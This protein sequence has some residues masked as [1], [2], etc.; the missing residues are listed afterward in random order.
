M[1]FSAISIG[2]RSRS[3]LLRKTILVMKLTTLMLLVALVQASARGYGQKITLHENSVPL[4]N[5]LQSIKKQTGYVFISNNFDTESIKVSINVKDAELDDALRSCFKD[6]PLSYKIVEKTV[7]IEQREQSL[8]D[9]LKA[10]IQAPPP[11]HIAGVLLDVNGRALPSVSVRVKNV[12]LKEITDSQGKFVIE[13]L[14]EGTV[15]QFTMVGFKPF[16]GVI[17]KVKNNYTIAAVD[18]KQADQIKIIATGDIYAEI[19]LKEAINE[20]NEIVIGYGTTTRA[21]NTGSVVTITAKDIENQPVM[22][23]LLALRGLVPG[24]VITPT[25]GIASAPVKI[26]IRGRN[27][28]NPLVSADPLILIDGMP[29][30]T[31]NLDGTDQSKGANILPDLSKYQLGSI[32]GTPAGGESPLFGLNPKDIESITVLKD[33]DATAIYGSRGANGVIL[34]NTKK[35]KSHRT[36]FTASAS[37]GFNKVMRHYNMM[38]TSQYVAMRKEA[39]KNDGLP[40]DADNAPDLVVWDTTRN[41]DWQ[42]QLWGGLG[43]VT[44]VTLGLTGGSENTGFRLSGNYSR[45][46]GILAVAGGSSTGNIAFNIDHHTS[47][48]K[49]AVSFSSIYTNAA[50]DQVNQGALAATLP[51][52]APPIYNKAGGLNFLEWE[53]PG[54]QLFGDYPFASLFQKTQSSTN[55]LNSNLNISVRPFK[56]FEAKVSFGYRI[57][58]DNVQSFNPMIAQDP[59]SFQKPT[60]SA[61]FTNV[62]SKGWVMEPQLNYTRKIGPG[63]LSALLGSTIQSSDSRY[64]VETGLGYNNDDLLKSILNA[65]VTRAFDAY[66][67]YKYNG[68]FGRLNYNIDDKYILNFNGR[69]DGSSR[70]GPGNQFGN[71]GSIGGAWVASSEKWFKD[72]MP[73][74][75]T[76]FKLRASYG[77]TGSDGVADYVYLSRW[78]SG[79]SGDQYPGYGNVTRPLISQQADNQIFHWQA[80][81]A[82]NQGLEMDFLDNSRITLQVDHYRNRCNNQLLNYP[83]PAFTGFT[84]VTANWPA[85]VQNS[86]WEF[87]LTAK[88]ISKKDFSWVISSNISFNSNKLLAY[89]NIQS[90]PYFNKLLVGQSLSTVYLYHYLGVSP[91]NGNYAIQDYNHDGVISSGGLNYAPLSIQNDNNVAVKLNPQYTGGINTQ[92]NFKGVY[93]SMLFD[94][95]KQIGRNAFVSNGMPGTILFNQPEELVNNHWQKPGDIKPYRA[96]STGTVQESNSVQNSIYFNASDGVYTDAS[97]IRLS[98]L[99]VAYNLP[100]VVAARLGMK[101]CNFFMNAEN[102]FV[103]TKYKGVDPEIQ[104]FNIM[105]QAKVFTAGLSFTY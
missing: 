68:I 44:N 77:V 53:S 89:P 104:N 42:K 91:L 34:I 65:P 10:Y 75:V 67:Q 26:Q 3:L 79:N 103:L 25:S 95:V 90:S 57:T 47:D 63:T 84:S 64:N 6:L 4:A 56:G 87:T 72:L 97:F 92:F 71:F 2:A 36:D 96:Y 99:S 18:K 101:G 24:M 62:L 49:V 105:P 38:N 45:Q 5:V 93:V 21:T 76:F 17:R 51:P 14:T 78:A 48:Q 60:G 61:G 85:T 8:F 66:G 16:E 74:F 28:I 54:F 73:S 81:K 82:L 12:G 35:N 15:I 22:N 30:T 94:F 1:K 19:T 9:K 33:A 86:G 70:F 80:N 98:N 32:G 11:I 83:T 88:V 100:K 41:V 37:E 23:P 39:L 102:V 50:T 13:N 31:L 27:N 29:I 55:S 43:R 40:V 7:V 52:D 59:T 58:L 69:R 20:L 46:V